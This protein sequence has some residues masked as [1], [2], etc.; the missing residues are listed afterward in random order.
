MLLLTMAEVLKIA[1][2]VNEMRDLLP[3]T[4]VVVGR[5]VE[6]LRDSSGNIKENLKI[7]DEIVS[8]ARAAEYRVGRACIAEALAE[9]GIG[10]FN[11]VRSSDLG[12]PIWPR[13]FTGSLAHKNQVSVA[14]VSKSSDMLSIGLDLEKFDHSDLRLTKRIATDEELETGPKLSILQKTTLIFSIKESYFKYFSPI[15]R[16]R[17]LDFKDFKIV[18][19]SDEATYKIMEIADTLKRHKIP[20][21]KGC[22]Y[23]KQD[24]VWSCCYPK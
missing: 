2:L 18:W 16:T 5:P 14:V 21:A 24:H 12:G 22:F 23:I 13:G 1:D 3:T 10:E 15:A 9:L 7:E 8:V 6:I 11:E 4:I 20:A 19:K 17:E